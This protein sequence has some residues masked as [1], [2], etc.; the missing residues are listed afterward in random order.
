MAKEKQKQYDDFTMSSLK[1]LSTNKVSVLYSSV[2]VNLRSDT[3][4]ILHCT[5]NMTSCLFSNLG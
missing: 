5:K 2:D 3:K 1:Q 4:I